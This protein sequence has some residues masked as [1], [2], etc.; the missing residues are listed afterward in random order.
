MQ[1][2][3]KKDDFKVFEKGKEKAIEVPILE[4][5]NFGKHM[6]LDDKNLGKEGY[7][8]LSNPETG[9]IAMMVMTRKVEILKKI[10]DKVPSKIR[11][12]VKTISKDLASNYDWLARSHFSFAKRVADKF[13][14]IKLG[15]EAVQAIRV[16][17]RQSILRTER[18][19]KEARIKA[20]KEGKNY[21]NL[22]IFK[23][24]KFRN[25]ETRKELLARS[26]GLLFKF[27]GE[28]T[29]AQKIRAEILFKEYEEIKKAYYLMVEFRN[30]YRPRSPNQANKKL[31]IWLR[32]VEKS[33]LSEMKNF[34]FTV[35]NHRTDILNFF[36]TGKSNA[37]AEGLNSHLQRFFINNYG[38]R[39]RDFFHFRIK[40]AFS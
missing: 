3:L 20:K 10:L 4:L 24:E 21:K 2:W 37:F 13:H 28:W 29:E 32:N 7:T 18:K 33:G 8:I 16:K 34:S 23:N 27:P 12:K 36:Y 11:L 6:C 22:P 14:V 39:N 1:S 35:K 40:L 26:R 17:L 30:F 9:K 31:D 5:E 38:I 15:F 19:L 25:G